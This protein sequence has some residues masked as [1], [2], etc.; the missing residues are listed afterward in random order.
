MRGVARPVVALLL[1]VGLAG[2]AA[3]CAKSESGGATSSGVK[4]VADGKLTVCTHLPY[5]PFQFKNDAG[6]IVGFDIDLMGLVAKKLKLKQAIVDTPFE[7]IKSGQDLN[8]GQCDVAAAGMTINAE[9][10]KVLDF[11]DPYFNA[12]QALLVRPGSKFPSLAS[13]KG[14]KLGTQ[15][16]T[17][18][19]EYARRYAKK[20]GY[21]TVSYKDLAALQQA[22]VTKQ[23]DAAIDDLPVMTTYVKHNKGKAEVSAQFD[24]GEQ[25]GYAVKKNGNPKLLA[26]INQVLAAARKDGR[27]DRIYAKWIGGKPGELPSAGA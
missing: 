7:G 19:E 1:A 17:T 11:S 27:Y 25:Y 12:N 6:K 23:V 9:R 15:A 2:A 5:E 26:T 13:L 20:Y 21:T 8:S 3:G 22:L 24:T 4:L 14:H 16:S 10:K 18:G